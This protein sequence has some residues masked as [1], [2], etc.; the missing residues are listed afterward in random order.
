MHIR[1]WKWISIVGTYIEKLQV[2]QVPRDIQKLYII[3]LTEG[4]KRKVWLYLK[5]NEKSRKD[6][7]YNG[8]KKDNRTNNDLLHR[9]LKIE[10]HDSHKN[11]WGEFMWLEG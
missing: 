3:S 9:K 10:Q 5:G 8:I 11:N 6:R 7:Q 4:K 2:V 1:D